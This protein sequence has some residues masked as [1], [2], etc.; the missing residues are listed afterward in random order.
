M[1]ESLEDY[2]GLVLTTKKLMRSLNGLFLVAGGARSERLT[3]FIALDCDR[4]LTS[5]STDCC[6]VSFWREFTRAD[7]G[8][9]I[10]SV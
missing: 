3:S 1:R 4:M 2:L 7:P 6:C 10:I 8:R 9:L 5:A